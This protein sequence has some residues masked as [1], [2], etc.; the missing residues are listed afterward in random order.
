LTVDTGSPGIPSEARACALASEQVRAQTYIGFI[1]PLAP[2]PGHVRLQASSPGSVIETSL[3]LHLMRDRL[4][5][6]N[7]ARYPHR[8]VQATWSFNLWLTF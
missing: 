1:R 3:Q 6:G 7:R 2:R 8:A 4:H 5:A